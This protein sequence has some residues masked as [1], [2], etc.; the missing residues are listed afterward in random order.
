[1]LRNLLSNAF[2]F[3]DSGSVDLRIGVARG[4]WNP[5]NHELN[6]APAVISFAIAD[7]GIGIP[8]D[9]HKIIFEAFQQ[10]DGTTSRKYG[11]TGLGLSISRD[12]AKVL[13]GEI[14]VQSQPGNGSTFTLFLPRA[15]QPTARP[16]ADAPE[17]VTSSPPR[18]AITDGNG[19]RG[20]G[21]GSRRP[22]ARADESSTARIEAPATDD[23][24]SI[25]P[26]DRVLLVI[27]DEAAFT[28]VVR[29]RARARGFKVV[30][31]SEGQTGISLAREIKPHAITLDIRLPGM[32]GWA[33]LDRLKHDPAIRH[34]PV[35]VLSVTDESHCAMK[36]GARGAR[37][38]PADPHDLDR[39]LDQIG[40]FLDRP[41]REL[42]IVED[43][44]NQA[45]SIVELLAGDDLVTAIATSGEEALD[46]MRTGRFDCVVVDIGLPGMSGFDLIDQMKDDPKLAILPVVVYTAR[47]LT[48]AEQSRL[49]AAAEAVILK[50]ANSPERLLDETALFLHRVEENLA[51]NQ[52]KMLEHARLSDPALAG[53]HVL[54]VDDDVRN[55][56][57]LTAALEH[58]FGMQVVYADNGAQGIDILQHANHVDVVLMDVMMPDLDGY[59]TIRRMRRL[60]GHETIP[61]IALTAKA[62]KGDREKCLESGASDYIAKPVD[63]D[64][65]V[66]LIRVWVGNRKCEPQQI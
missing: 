32:N 55:V 20:D 64:Q 45:N 46:L 1:V 34:I 29:D 48:K 3:T 59:E 13:H 9:K 47:D 60:P 39:M 6:R 56:F 2:K 12:L 31:A 44:R 42:L 23:R 54:I 50:D 40:E 25:R 8:P 27:D 28:R 49:R 57:A 65:L 10:A 15:I 5:Q 21:N 38:K 43:D 63:T 36:L 66:S 7:T 61:I 30:I 51:P 26:E 19:K 14:S 22:A 35:H 4:G 37:I 52:R 18:R 17:P 33:V 53:T 24:V 62:M 41:R 58:R 11:G 16:A